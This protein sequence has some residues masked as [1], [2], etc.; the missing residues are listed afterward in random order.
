MTASPQPQQPLIDE[1]RAILVALEHARRTLGQRVVLE[2]D[3]L[4]PRLERCAR[5]LSSLDL[6]ERDGI[7]PT[8]LA[9]LDELE[10]TISAFGEER[11]HLADKL[12]SRSRSLAAGAAY[13]QAKVR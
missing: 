9:L 4:W 1:L 8:M 2:A 7:K 5:R 3:D 6:D 11:R 13:H 12:K 10:K